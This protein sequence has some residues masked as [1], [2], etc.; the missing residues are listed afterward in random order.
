MLRTF[1]LGSVAADLTTAVVAL[2]E[3]VVA[4]N[5]A[6]ESSSLM[7][8]AFMSFFLGV[9]GMSSVLYGFLNQK[10]PQV[11]TIE[12]LAGEEAGA[13]SASTP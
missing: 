3:I 4:G 10:L 12:Y 9:W 6:S 2:F 11:I 5:A 13:R 7:A 8:F 1:A